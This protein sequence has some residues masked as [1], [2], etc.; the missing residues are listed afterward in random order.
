MGRI[1]APYGV[2]GWLH[3]ISATEP[4]E[5][6]LTWSPWYLGKAD[7]W[8]PIEVVEGRW[9][10]KGLVVQLAGVDGRDAA[11][12]LKGWEIAVPRHRLP[13]LPEGEYYWV[14]LIGLQ[15]VTE[16]G[17]PL[18]EIDHLLETGAND[19]LVV[20]GERERLIP[21]VRDQYVREID[22]AARRMVV[23]WDPEF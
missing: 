11:A 3:V 10:G 22:L 1:G 6:L 19:V 21:Y 4:P 5:A 17:E 20:R 16:Q 13:P 9:H 8:R 7:Q 18:G 23:A 2:R 15:V 12:A 14:D